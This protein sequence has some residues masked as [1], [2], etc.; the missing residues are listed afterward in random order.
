MDTHDIGPT[1][2][3][4]RFRTLKRN[5]LGSCAIGIIGGQN[6]IIIQFIEVSPTSG[7]VEAIAIQAT[8]IEP[9]M[10]SGVQKVKVQI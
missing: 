1:Q 4:R 2:I 5:D 10:G 8:L 3:Q 9:I 6:S 7:R